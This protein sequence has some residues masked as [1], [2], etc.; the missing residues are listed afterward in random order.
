MPEAWVSGRVMASEN[1]LISNNRVFKNGAVEA[2][3]G[4]KRKERRRFKA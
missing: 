2:T 3:H 1:I 4:K